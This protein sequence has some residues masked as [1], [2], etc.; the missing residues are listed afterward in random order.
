MHMDYSDIK[1]EI[2]DNWAQ[3]SEMPHY[4]DLLSELAESALPI[5]YSD[6]IQDWREMP[7]EYT[8]SWKDTTEA[9]GDSTIF[10][11][12]GVDLWNYYQDT[13]RS[14]FTEIQHEKELA[15]EEL[16]NA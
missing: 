4:Q 15:A 10:S 2:L 9:N 16:E 8:D 7:D 5:Y 14:I 3:L 13:Y 12:M 6:I 11:L 1:A